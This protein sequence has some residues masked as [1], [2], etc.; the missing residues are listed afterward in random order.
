MTTN[1]APTIERR[2]ACREEPEVEE[3]ARYQADGVEGEVEAVPPLREAEPILVD[4]RRGGDERER[5]GAHEREYDEERGETGVFE[6]D[7]EPAGGLRHGAGR[8]RGYGL[9]EEDA[10]DERD[11]ADEGKRHEEA[12]PRC[13]GEHERPEN[14]GDGGRNDDHGLNE[15]EHRFPSPPVVDVFDHRHRDRG[16]GAAADG[17]EDAEGD[18]VPDIPRYGA[19]GACGDVKGKSGQKDGPAAVPIRE[20]PPE[21]QPEAEE[22]EEEY[23]GQ[24]GEAGGDVEEV[25]HA[26]KGR[27]VEIGRERDEGGEQ[28][29][30]DDKTAITE[31]SPGCP[32]TV[33]GLIHGIVS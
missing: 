19:T 31:I 1:P 32:V 33:G 13:V 20:R 16:G 29:D 30:K 28:R 10:A 12:P 15:S 18:E 9:F 22:E 24:V 4:I 21:E 25:A 7:P 5:C 11:D 3:R 8:P 17:L 23:Q 2:L 26:G 14:R 27:E 6:H